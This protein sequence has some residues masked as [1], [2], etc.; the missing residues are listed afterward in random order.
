MTNYCGG[1]LYSAVLK[2]LEAD[3]A[4]ALSHLSVYYNSPSG[5]GE[6]SDLHA[7]FRKWMLALDQAESAIETA[8]KW[9]ASVTH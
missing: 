7:E 8:K 9:I 2:G 4:I 5:I 6:H 3:R 1:L